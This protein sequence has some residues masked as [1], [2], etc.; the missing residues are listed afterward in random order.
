M[1][2]KILPLPDRTQQALDA[3]R[4]SARVTERLQRELRLH[5]AEDDALHFEVTD[6]NE[7]EQKARLEAIAT[8][9]GLME[10]FG[11]EEVIRWAKYCALGRV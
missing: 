2:G 9:D 10:Q 8:I 5:L 1:N 11:P 3:I 4:E 7:R 6:S